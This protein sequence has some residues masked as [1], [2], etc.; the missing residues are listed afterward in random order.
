MTL[1]LWFRSPLPWTVLLV[2]D[3]AGCA[4][5]TTA[6]PNVGV[7]ISGVALSF[8]LTMM[9]RVPA[10][11]LLFQTINCAVQTLIPG[12]LIGGLVVYGLLLG[13]P[14]GSPFRW[15]FSV[16]LVLAE[17][18][19][20]AL[21]L[22]VTSGVSRQAMIAAL[23]GMVPAMEGDLLISWLPDGGVAPAGEAEELARGMLCLRWLMP[24]AGD[25]A[26]RWVSHYLSD[27]G[28]DKVRIIRENTVEWNKRLD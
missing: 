5:L 1:H 19:L 18:G 7:G 21:F 2:T 8:G 28:W 3:G 13:L 24:V 26:G 14:E 27:N 20:T 11:H 10:P 9:A 6:E 22:L 17:T 23:G 16:G 4:L 15:S 12:G 25:I